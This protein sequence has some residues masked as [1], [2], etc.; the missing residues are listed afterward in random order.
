MEE[1][2]EEG[3]TS[4]PEPSVAFL[5]LVSSPEASVFQRDAEGQH[6][7]SSRS[8]ITPKACLTGYFLGLPRGRF[9]GVTSRVERDVLGFGGLCEALVP[10]LLRRAACFFF[11]FCSCFGAHSGQNQS[12]SGTFFKGGDKQVCDNKKKIGGQV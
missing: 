6:N 11:P 5:D 2:P 12:P 4:L 9:S 8:N 1:H 3:K 10:V 7:T